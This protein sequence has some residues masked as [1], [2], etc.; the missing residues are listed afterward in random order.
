MYFKVFSGKKQTLKEVSFFYQAL[1]KMEKREFSLT[2]P[3]LLLGTQRSFLL[4][5]LLVVDVSIIP[6]YSK[7]SESTCFFNNIFGK[8]VYLVDWC[9]F[10]WYY[11]EGEAIQ[12]KSEVAVVVLYFF[13]SHNSS[14]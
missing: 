12:S 2:R 11:F 5:D 10:G 13:N 7:K 1:A 3:S 14:Y 9:R 8:E 4:F 6:C